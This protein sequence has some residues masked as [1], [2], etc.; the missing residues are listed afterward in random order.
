MNKHPFPKDFKFGVS[1]SAYQIEGAWKE[2]GKGSSIWD[3]FAHEHP[4]LIADGSNGDV[5]CDSFHHY[6]E[7]VALLKELGAQFYRFSISWPRILPNGTINN[8]NEEGI[9]YYTNLLKVILWLLQRVQ[10]DGVFVSAATGKR[11]R[12]DRDPLPRRSSLN[13]PRNGRME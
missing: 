12:A 9:A 13:I 10:R 8:I 11:D 2:D 7:D 6:R 1:T 3:D 4:E 5:A